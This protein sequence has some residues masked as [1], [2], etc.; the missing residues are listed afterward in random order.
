MTD[1]ETLDDL[2]ADYQRLR[3]LVGPDEAA[4]AQLRDERAA[5]ERWARDAEAGLGEL[6]GR[7]VELEAEIAALRAEL[8]AAIDAEDNPDGL[9]PHTLRLRRRDGS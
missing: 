8:A 7:I 4:Y 2:R 3:A 6:R 5:A 9:P 1:R